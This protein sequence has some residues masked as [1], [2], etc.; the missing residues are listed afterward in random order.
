MSQEVLHA[1]GS[2][3][4]SLVAG[5]WWWTAGVALGIEATVAVVGFGAAVIVLLTVQTLPLWAFNIVGALIYVV[6]VPIGAAALTYA[7]GTLTAR[8]DRVN[9]AIDMPDPLA[10]PAG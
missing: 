1:Q 7:Y 5:R 4:R 6:L 8:H 9:D 2:G 10:A 3:S